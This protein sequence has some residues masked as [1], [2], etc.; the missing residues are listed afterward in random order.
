MR[1]LFLLLGLISTLAVNTA[2]QAQTQK[3]EA[4]E[5]FNNGKASFKE[6]KYAE[7]ANSFR[8]ANELNPNWKLLYNIAQSDAAAKMHGLA[9]QAFEAYLSQGGDDVP[10]ERRTLVLEEVQ[11]LRNMVGLVQIEAPDGAIIFIDDVK[12]GQAPMAG[13][14]PVAASVNH[15]MVVQLDGEEISQRTVNVIG[16]QTATIEIA[17]PKVETPEPVVP[18]TIPEQD[19]PEQE[20]QETG[21]MEPDPATAEVEE[22]SSRLKLWG[23]VTVGVGGALI[24]GGTV[25]GIMTL[26][27]NNTIKEKCPEG[28][29]LPSTHEDVDKRDSMAIVTDVLLIGGALA[30]TAGVLMVIFA[31]GDNSESDDDPESETVSLR[32]IVTS[33]TVGT[34]LEWRF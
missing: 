18:E 32:P 4:L 6:K 8:R 33:Q 23:W 2:A 16:G 14:I 31:K 27:T 15:N 11:R 28:Y 10:E 19:E 34:V 7:A 26:S 29:C 22:G 13:Q 3:E 21:P 24:I 1:S 9:L 30:A 17:A 20:E 5:A 25:T 12:R